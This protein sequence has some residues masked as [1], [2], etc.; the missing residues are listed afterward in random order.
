MIEQFPWA[1]YSTKLVKSIIHPLYAGKIEK[2][3]EGY[4]LCTS[5]EPGLLRIYLLVN[6]AD[7]IIVDAKFQAFGE[8]L[9]IGSAEIACELLIEKNYAQAKRI[10]AELIEKSAEDRPLKKGF[11][12]EAAPYINLVLD[13]LDLALSQCEGLP[14]PEEFLVTPVDLSDLKRRV[15]QLGRP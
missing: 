11:P 8:T 10:S 4:R 12:K 3:K 15:P 14:M 6:E 13:T 2:S 7:G 5:E 1:T 9:L